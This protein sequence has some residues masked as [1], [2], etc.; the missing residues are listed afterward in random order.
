MS[1][2]NLQKRQYGLT[3]PLTRTLGSLGF[4]LGSD[5]KINQQ[6]AAKDLASARSLFGRGKRPLKTMRLDMGQMGQNVNLQGLNPGSQTT[7]MANNMYNNDDNRISGGTNS[8]QNSL[9]SNKQHQQR[10]EQ[11]AN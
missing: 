8:L 3:G 4:G 9:Q 7:K 6:A 1:Q 10:F 5:N 2:G 11:F